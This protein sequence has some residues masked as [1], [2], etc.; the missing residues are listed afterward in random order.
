M[1]PAVASQASGSR[2]AAL[3]FPFVL[4]VAYAIAFASVALGG[5]VVAFD[6]HPGQLYRLWHVVDNGPAPWAWNEGWWTGYPELQF[7]PPAFA[8]AGALLHVASLGVIS[9]PAAYQALVW[10]AYLAPGVTAWILLARLLA[11]GWL[12]LPGAFVTLTLSLWPTLMSGVEGGV[13]VGMVPARL[14]WALLPLLAATL[15]RWCEG[16]AA[17]PARR[18]VAIV[19]AVALTHPAHLPAAVLLVALAALAQDGRARRLVTALAGLAGAV[20]V[21]AFWTVPLLARLDDTRALAWGVL[22]PASVRDALVAHPLILVLAALAIAA[23]VLARSAAE[24]LVAR[25]PG[26]MAAVVALDAGVFEPIG[27]RWLPA[28]R[29]LDGFWLALVLAAGLAAGRLLERLASRLA[30]PAAVTAPAAVAAAIALSLAGHDTLA[31]W[32]RPSA[33]PSYASLE[34]G[35][36]LPALWTALRGAPPGR[37]LFVRS[38]VPIVYGTAWWRPHS[39]VTALAPQLARRAIVNGTFTHPSPIAA[40]VYRGD[41]G[42]GPITELVE[43]LDGRS[44]F[45]RPLQ[46]LDA[47]TLNAH[48]RRL[49]VSAIVALD[50]DLP[51]L[52]A[53]ADNPTFAAR[54]SEPP[55]V[56]WLGAPA[57]L[58]Q[59]LGSGRWRMTVEATVDGWASAGVAYYPLWRATAAGHSLPTRR[60]TFGD[61]EVRPPAGTTAFELGYRPGAAEWTGL[62]L[63]ASG[64]LAWLVLGVVPALLHR[65]RAGVGALLVLLAGAPAAADGADHPAGP[66][67]RSATR[68]GERLAVEDHRHRLPERRALGG[69]LGQLGGGAAEGRRRHGFGA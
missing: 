44:L 1:I 26:A 40:L 69:Q 51:R 39:H 28:D 37:V 11:N 29:V 66:H 18:A 42:R 43:R 15:A 10:L 38:A 19:A 36:R 13:H 68:G 35:L 31:L 32:P 20:L 14:A 4:L 2:S 58:P 23:M 55:F 47:A 61:L 54:R 41:A 8:Y 45:G 50:E 62:A 12:A 59:P 64:A 7:Y 52:P 21:T 22:T 34:R 33:W 49:G 48:A 24:R 27:L 6:D 9:V 46:E 16:L 56:I 25:L 60:G 63:T 65:R 30:L 5:A 3:L 57:P 53:L 67:D 17:F